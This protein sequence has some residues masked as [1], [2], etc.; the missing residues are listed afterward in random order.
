MGY[1]APDRQI[2]REWRLFSAIPRS[3]PIPLKDYPLIVRV[4][5][6]GGRRSGNSSTG[7]KNHTFFRRNSYSLRVI[8]FF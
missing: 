8:R 7:V 4:G 1:G 5:W 6:A 2:I 3:I